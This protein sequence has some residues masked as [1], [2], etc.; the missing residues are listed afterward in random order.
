MPRCVTTENISDAVA[1]LTSVDPDLK[2]LVDQHGIPPLWER[3]E[4]FDTLVLIILEQQVSLASA[5][6]TFRKLRDQLGEVTPAAVLTLDNEALKA[7]G[8]S[9]QKTRY[10]RILSEAVQDGSLNLEALAAAEDSQ[11]RQQLMSLKGVGKWT[12][13]IY[14]LMA[15]R[16]ADI[17][18]EGDL[19]LAATIQAIKQ[20]PLRP[21]P[22]EL[23]RVAQSWKPWRAVAARI[24]WNHYL[25]C[26]RPTSGTTEL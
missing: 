17:W 14:L 4:G 25:I 20:Y 7:V 24:L 18:P 11:V 19:A 2:V 10:V 3:E 26:L 5:R 12:A 15:L 9:R 23:I 1:Y 16:R 22:D 21:K 8:F 13:D 6:A